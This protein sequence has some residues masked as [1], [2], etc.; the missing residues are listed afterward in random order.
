MS[1]S[2]HHC[3]ILI[4]SSAR[5][6]YEKDKRSNPGNLLSEFGGP[7]I[8]KYCH[9]SL[10]VTEAQVHRHGTA[11][12]AWRPL[13]SLWRRLVQ[14]CS[15]L[16]LQC[17]HHQSFCRFPLPLFVQCACSRGLDDLCF[18]SPAGTRIFFFSPKRPD[19]SGC[20]G[21]G[22]FPQI[23]WR[24]HDVDHAPPSS[25]EGKNA[26]SYISFLPVCLH[27]VDMQGFMSPSNA[28]SEC[29]WFVGKVLS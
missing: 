8:E 13:H 4:A 7:W 5:C 23:G 14:T 3:S 19:R 25:A 26:W 11:H 12:A 20:P 2:F 27:G 28:F 10:V 1:V 18:D 24:G 29:R 17:C 9:L 21:G 22:S 15:M 16:T 6:P